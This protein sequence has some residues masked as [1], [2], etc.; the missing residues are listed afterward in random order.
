MADSDIEERLADLLVAGC[1]SSSAA[2]LL[3][4]EL[5]LSKNRIYGIVNGLNICTSCK[6][7]KQNR[8]ATFLA[9]EPADS[10][11]GREHSTSVA[12]GCPLCA[13]KAREG[14]GE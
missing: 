11:A 1:S 3:S 7:W 4:K 14:R 12:S 6:E 10:D 8:Q 2:K 13:R 5:K 9:Q